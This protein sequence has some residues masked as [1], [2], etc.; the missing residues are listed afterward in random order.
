METLAAQHLPKGYG[1]DWTSLSYQQKQEGR[2]GTY[3]IIASLVFAYLFLVAQYESW[4][5]PVSVILST[6]LAALGALTALFLRDLSL[7]VYG[8]I[9]LVLLVGLAAKNAILIVEFAK[10]R[11]EAGESVR[12]AALD[13][14]KTR[15]RAVLMTALAFIFGVLPLVFASGAGAGAR[16]AIGTTVFGG[17]LLATMLGTIIVPVLFVALEVL[18]QRT[19]RFTRRKRQKPVA[20][21]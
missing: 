10:T 2:A 13:G 1:F 6:A 20:V 15:F 11:L 17:M 19:E 7:G 18:T 14:A 5:L 12:D 9:G 21:R 16:R 8:Q 3:A 4:S